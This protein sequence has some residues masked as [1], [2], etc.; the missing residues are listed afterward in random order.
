MKEQSSS[1]GAKIRMAR[2][3]ERLPV[4]LSIKY[5]VAREFVLEYAE[6]LSVGGLFIRGA[7]NLQRG[8]IVN[9]EIALPGYGA[10][11]VAA[12]VAHV[13][14]PVVAAKYGRK[15]GAGFAI[16]KSPPG[17][18][19]ALRAYLLRLGRRRDHVVFVSDDQ[20]AL[21]LDAAGYQVRPLPPSQGLLDAVA[22]SA[23]PVVGVVVPFDQEQEYVSRAATM[24]SP[25]IV[26]AVDEDEP[27]EDLLSWLDS[28]LFGGE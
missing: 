17:F 3:E 15:P 25:E 27:I 20:L 23:E 26:Y 7:Y 4:N 21:L 11:A 10:F 9:V 5:S 6:N 12:E 13:L 8:Q 18:A 1:D 14:S 2:L 19:E 28:E 22:G 16:T 24:G